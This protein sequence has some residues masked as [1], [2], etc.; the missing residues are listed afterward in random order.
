MPTNPLTAVQ[1]VRQSMKT[2][3]EKSRD[4]GLEVGVGLANHLARRT[5]RATPRCT[6]LRRTALRR[7]ALRRST[8]K[9]EVELRWA[10]SGTIGSI[11]G[12]AS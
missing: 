3:E 7:T 5:G 2:Q 1:F 11:G 10:E 8:Y 12:P 4:L 9:N 6:A